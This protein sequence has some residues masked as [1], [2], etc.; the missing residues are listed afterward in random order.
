M[1]DKCMKKKGTVSPSGASIAVRSKPYLLARDLDTIFDQFRK[2]FDDL[3][4][5]FLPVAPLTSTLMAEMP[6]TYP[7]VDLA[8]NGDHYTVTAELPGFSK[9]SVDIQINTDELQMRAHK[10]VETEEKKKNY[11]HRERAYSTFERTITFPEEVVPAKCEGEMKDG[12]I[13]LTI[14]KREPKPEEKKTKVKLK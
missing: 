12:I 1:S 3:M 14:P 5:P 8:D 7:A 4:E 9:E 13:E 11:M 6:V 10:K 2:S